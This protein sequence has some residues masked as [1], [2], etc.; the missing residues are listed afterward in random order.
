M[1]GWF[2]ANWCICA[3]EIQKEKDHSVGPPSWECFLW[4]VCSI[5]AAHPSEHRAITPFPY[6]SDLVTFSAVALP[7]LVQSSFLLRNKLS[8]PLLEWKLL[9]N[10]L[11]VVSSLHSEPITEHWSNTR[12][13]GRR[14]LWRLLWEAV[15][16]SM[17]GVTE[18]S[19]GILGS[20]KKLYIP[21]LF[22]NSLWDKT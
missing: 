9:K 19:C 21:R 3:T 12:F 16:N 20:Y 14:N 1:Q 11:L 7:W 6:C 15:P 5:I 2:E 18:S 17:W 13:E 8:C 22:R 10:R 4:L